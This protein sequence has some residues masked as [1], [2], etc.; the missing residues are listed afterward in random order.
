MNTPN[1]R[2]NQ[3]LPTVDQLKD[4][5]KRLRGE[6]QQRGTTMNHAGSLELLAHQLGYR[7]WN[8]LHAAAGNGPASGPPVQ[9][10]ERV[11]G[12]YLG[13]GFTGKVI[14]VDHRP[15]TGR[16]RVTFQFDEAV[17]V[18]RFEG[19]SAFRKRVSCFLGGDRQTVEK[20]S[21]GNPQ[22][23]LDPTVK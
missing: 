4:Q 20:T 15:T 10:G 22:L 17:D 23:R 21:D 9:L 12:T 19:M 3:I 16:Y 14:A 11:A 2:P 6:L 7:D 5:A 1:S 8:T 18:I 13:H